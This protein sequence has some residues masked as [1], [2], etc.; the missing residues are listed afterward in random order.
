MTLLSIERAR[1]SRLRVAAVVI[2]ESVGILAGLRLIKVRALDG[3]T[4][5]EFWRRASEGIS[6]LLEAMPGARLLK[7]IRAVPPATCEIAA[8]PH[9]LRRLQ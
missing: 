4:W 3:S 8:L 5:S 9:P 6:C 2:G 1:S 7:V